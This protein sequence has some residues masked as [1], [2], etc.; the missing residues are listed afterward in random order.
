MMFA[1]NKGGKVV[2]G[3]DTKKTPHATAVEAALQ[4]V[5]MARDCVTAAK[6][7]RSRALIADAERDLQV[8]IDRARDV[9]VLWGQIGLTLGIARGNA[10]QR[11]RK[12]HSGD[13]VAQS[14][15]RLPKSA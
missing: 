5:A 11:Y 12:R 9:D 2:T 14:D 6:Q 7:T 3:T 4:G 8:A 13:G 10:Y 15:V 1:V